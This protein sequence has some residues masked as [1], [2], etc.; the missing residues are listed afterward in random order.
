MTMSIVIKMKMQNQQ[1]KQIW[2]DNVNRYKDTNLKQII[3]NTANTI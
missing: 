3:W 1:Q 2:D